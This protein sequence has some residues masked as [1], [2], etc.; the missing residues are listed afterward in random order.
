MAD[1]GAPRMTGAASGDG[2]SRRSLLKRSLVGGGALIAGPTLLAACGGSSTS[3]SAS[4]A[5]SGL[6]K[7]QNITVGVVGD[8]VGYDPYYDGTPNFILLQNL[9]TFLVNY[10]DQ[11]NPL[12]AALTSWDINSTSD[13]VTLHIRPGLKL[14]TGNTFTAADL[15]QNFAKAANPT[16]GQQL[17]GP[18]SVVKSYKATDN[19]TVVLTFTQPVSHEYITDILESQPAVDAADNTTAYLAS[20]PAS[21]GPF[22]LVSREPGT[23]VVISRWPGYWDAKDVYLDQVTFRIFGSSSS[24]VSALLSGA[25]DAIYNMP[26][27]YA[28]QVKSNFN[29]VQGYPGALVQ[30]VRINTNTPPWNNIKLRQAVARAIDRNRIVQ[31][32]YY[33][34][35]QPLYLPWGPHSPANDPSYATKNSYDLAAAKQLLKEAGSPSGAEALADGSDSDA[36]TML[37]IMQQSLKQIGFNLTI[38]TL[39]NATFDTRLLAGEFGILLGGIGNSSKSPSRIDTNSIFRITDNP[40]LKNNVPPAYINAIQASMRAVTPAAAQAA[41]AQLNQVISEEAFG[42]AVCTI[43]YLTATKKTLVGVTRDVDDRLVLQG[44]KVVS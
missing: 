9:N 17:N 42:I 7:N 34:Y 6:A 3:S 8:I 38:T 28:A 30:T 39:D 5:A 18:M 41:Y 4:T 43:P 19:L 36:L 40:V 23:N 22:Q 1:N 24:M 35:S 20:K 10:D 15:V 27:S 32:V 26:A 14:Q 31:E 33:G 21:G 25:V 13:Q 29:I 12:P 16:L 2:I 11:L 44:A 37:Q